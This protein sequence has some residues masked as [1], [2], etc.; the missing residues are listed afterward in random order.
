[1]FWFRH[2]SK[3]LER[4]ASAAR[5][6]KH[7]TNINTTERER[8]HDHKGITCFGQLSSSCLVWLVCV[9]FV[10]SSECF[11]VQ[12]QDGSFLKS[13]KFQASWI[14]CSEIRT[15]PAFRMLASSW[16]VW[17]RLLLFGCL[18]LAT[19]NRIQR[20]IIQQIKKINYFLRDF[21]QLNLFKNS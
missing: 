5:Y 8:A 9:C 7:I 21:I 6:N 18:R 13:I 16:D 17:S 10:G 11:S 14:F 2:K 3:T 19:K 4:S 12:I 15:D 1:M 20:V